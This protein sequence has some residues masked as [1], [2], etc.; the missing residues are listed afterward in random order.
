MGNEGR[1]QSAFSMIDFH[2]LPIDTPFD[3]QTLIEFQCDDA[4]TAMGHN[5]TAN[6]ASSPVDVNGMDVYDDHIMHDKIHCTI[7]I[8]QQIPR[9]LSQ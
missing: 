6:I 3:V 1:I 2:S 9:T 5:A 7:D 8:S 4:P